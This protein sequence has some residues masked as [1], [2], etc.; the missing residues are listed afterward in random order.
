MGL[1]MCHLVR[2]LRQLD[3]SPAADVPTNCQ[4]YLNYQCF[5]SGT[6]LNGE[7]IG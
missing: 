2:S 6:I 7:N 1:P 3:I 5:V 4:T